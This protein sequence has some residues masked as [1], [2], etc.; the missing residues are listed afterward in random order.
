MAAFDG[1]F[2]ATFVVPDRV[3][4]GAIVRAG[5]E[6]DTDLVDTLDAG[7]KLEVLER[8]TN[9]KGTVRYRL[10]SPCAGWVS[11]KSV[12]FV[13]PPEPEPID[14]EEDL[15]A[16]MKQSPITSTGA[17]LFKVTNGVG[18]VTF[19]QP[20]NNNAMTAAIFIGLLRCIK[21]AARVVPRE[22]GRPYVHSARDRRYAYD[23]VGT[24]RVMFIKSSGRIWCAGGDP[25]D[26]QK[27]QRQNTG[28]EGASAPR[29]PETASRPPPAPGGAPEKKET[30]RPTARTATQ[31]RPRTTTN[32]RSSSRIGS[33]SSTSAPCPS[34]RS[35]RARSSA[36]ASAS[37]PSATWSSPRSARSS[38]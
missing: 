6:L 7:T 4:K 2:P 23:N 18:V 24:V 34:S 37:A 8:G 25:K 16:F 27:A 36:A 12:E 19:N 28:A 30:R 13:P 38:S 21:R 14:P 3:K 1:A 11:E 29:P 35:S 22:R 31:A 32:R 26:F 5:C 20:E 17:V 15:E 10:A 9:A 33:S